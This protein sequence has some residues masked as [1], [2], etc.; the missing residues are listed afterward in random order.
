MDITNPALVKVLTLLRLATVVTAAQR[1]ICQSNSAVFAQTSQRFESV[2][3][4]RWVM[5]Q[6]D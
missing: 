5:Q 6:T 3:P 2:L 4:A 1:F